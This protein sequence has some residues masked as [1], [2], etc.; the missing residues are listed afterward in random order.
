MPNF[1][2]NLSMQTVPDE[3]SIDKIFQMSTIEYYEALARLAEDASLAPFTGLF[4]V[5]F[6]VI[7]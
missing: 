2:F 4:P 3:Y 6:Y 7:V 1:A 5:K